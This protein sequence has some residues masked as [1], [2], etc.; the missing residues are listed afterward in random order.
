[1]ADSPFHVMQSDG[2][3][4][5]VTRSNF[6]GGARFSHGMGFIW[7]HRDQFHLVT[8]WHNFSGANPFDG[9]HL[10][11]GGT[12]RQ[13]TKRASFWEHR[14]SLSSRAFSKLE[15]AFRAMLENAVSICKAQCGGRAETAGEIASR[16]QA[17][18]QPRE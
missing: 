2:L 10:S 6:F 7:K 14:N 11:A 12:S 15:P 5:A 1:M 3:S 16:R 13:L 18:R 17:R 9:S 8:N 4:F